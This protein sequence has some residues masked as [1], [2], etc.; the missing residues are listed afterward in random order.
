MPRAK[1]KRIFRP[2]GGR[3]WKSV[4]ERWEWTPKRGLWCFYLDGTKCKSDYDSLKQMIERERPLEV[5]P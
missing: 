4:V 1:T 3:Y 5:T 2:S